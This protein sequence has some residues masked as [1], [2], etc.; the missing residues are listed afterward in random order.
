[1]REIGNIDLTCSQVVQVSPRRWRRGRLNPIPYTAIR[2]T[3]Y[4][5]FFF[6]SRKEEKYILDSE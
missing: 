5:L 4:G 1:M 6:P 2:I 3:Q